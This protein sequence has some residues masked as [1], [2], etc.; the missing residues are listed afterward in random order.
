MTHLGLWLIH[1][2]ATHPY[3]WPVDAYL[4]AV[5]LYVLGSR[6]KAVTALVIAIILTVLLIWG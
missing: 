1:F 2:A 3:I 6:G 5:A 4:L